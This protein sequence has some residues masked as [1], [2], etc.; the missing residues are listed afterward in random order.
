MQKRSNS[1]LKR[2]ERK[3]QMSHVQQKS[4][5][6]LKK[7]ERKLRKHPVQRR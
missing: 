7:K 5:S 3:L 4:N 2:K 6:P 1:L